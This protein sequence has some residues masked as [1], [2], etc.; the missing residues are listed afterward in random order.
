MLLLEYMGLLA[1]L[2]S[3]SVLD[4]VLG[5]FCNCGEKEFELC[6]DSAG[7]F[8]RNLLFDVGVGNGT[9]LLSSVVDMDIS[10]RSANDVPVGTFLICSVVLRLSVLR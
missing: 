7:F 3:K 10:L 8:L 9:L 4:A 2:S 6:M 1:R 5:F